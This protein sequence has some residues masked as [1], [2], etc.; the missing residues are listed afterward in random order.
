MDPA[1]QF[2]NAYGYANNPLIMV[3]PDGKFFFGLL[4]GAAVTVG[5]AAEGA[6]LG[7]VGNTLGLMN[8]IGGG[9]MD[10]YD[11]YTV[12]SGCVIGSIC[13]AAGSS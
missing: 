5:A 2:T 7:G 4:L 3:D 9:S 8:L 13:Q 12:Y 10:W 1:E 11:G 6:A